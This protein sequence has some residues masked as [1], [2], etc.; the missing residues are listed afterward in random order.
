MLLSKLKETNKLIGLE[1]KINEVKKESQDIDILNKT[2]DRIIKKVDNYTKSMLI[3]NKEYKEE[4][5]LEDLDKIKKRLRKYRLEAQNGYYD[6]ELLQNI[7]SDISELELTLQQRWKQY[8][9]SNTNGLRNTIMSVQEVVKD[10]SKVS[11]VLAALHPSKNYWPMDERNINIIRN[12][13]D[14]GKIIIE[15][16]GLNPKIEKFLTKISDNTATILDLD[17][18]ILEWIR[19]KGLESKMSIGFKKIYK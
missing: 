16:L 2:I 14:T 9:D 18:E 15:E 6:N 13:I 17:P 1:Q 4:F 11:I 10:K 8:L 7:Y 5:I 19:V 12:N 3:L